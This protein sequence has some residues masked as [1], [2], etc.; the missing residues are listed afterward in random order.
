MH[1][2]NFRRPIIV[3][4]C[5]YTYMTSKVKSLLGIW[6]KGVGLTMHW[7]TQ[8]THPILKQDEE[9]LMEKAGCY[10]ETSLFGPHSLFWCI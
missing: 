7:H 2:W 9:L 6:K 8:H 1:V 4:V 3:C 10:F 5:V